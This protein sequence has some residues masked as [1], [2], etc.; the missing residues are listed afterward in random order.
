MAVRGSEG[1][2]HLGSL[3]LESFYRVYH[4]RG[5]VAFGHLRESAGFSGILFFL[6]LL[7]DFLFFYKLFSFSR[8]QDL[9][10]Q[11]MYINI[12]SFW[13][14]LLLPCVLFSSNLFCP[15]RLI[16]GPDLPFRYLFFLSS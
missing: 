15:S 9:L 10:E 4:L 8:H 14:H 1:P 7:S 5:A 16:V 13:L 2:R 11:A 3:P 12:E 6:I